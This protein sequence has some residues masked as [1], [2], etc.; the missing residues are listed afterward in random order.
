MIPATEQL[1]G[2]SFSLTAPF[3]QTIP[4]PQ[5]KAEG[6][7]LKKEFYMKIKE[8]QAKNILT[9]SNLPGV[10]YVINPYTGCAFSCQ[11]CYACFMSRFVN[12]KVEDWGSY[13]Y[14][15]TNAS[16]LLRKNL[17]S[18]K[19]KTSSIFIASVTDAWQYVEKKY[20]ITR[21]ILKILSEYK[22]PGKISLLTKS[23][24][25]ERDIDIIKTIPNIDVGFTITSSNNKIT[26]FLEG[27]APRVSQRLEAMKK[28]NE[29]NIST[30]AFIGPVLPHFYSRKEE[31]E[32]VFKS[33]KNAGTDRIFV[34]RLNT[35]GLI[36]T[37]LKPLLDKADEQTKQSFYNSKKYDKEL[38]NYIYYLIKKYDMTLLSKEII[39][40]NSK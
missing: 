12:E 7:H 29:N 28:F 18:L 31:L 11:Y 3:P 32:N 21:E 24:L 16:E 20:E 1:R 10:D 14:V 13:V 26:A 23:N 2:R 4:C 25:I 34:E 9:K 19:N 38:N 36:M 27:K 33:I 22:Y 40:H 6:Y 37:R 8:I 39:Y 5:S 35:S 15:K 17:N 30:Y